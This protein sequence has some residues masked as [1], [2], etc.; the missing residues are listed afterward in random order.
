[1]S[2]LRTKRGTRTELRTLWP[3]PDCEWHQR[4]CS[5]QGWEEAVKRQREAASGQ[6]QPWAAGGR[7]R[8]SQSLSVRQR[9]DNVL[10]RENILELVSQ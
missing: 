7:G 2:V 6:V 8:G 4:A 3:G 9:G 5:T 1:M 10:G